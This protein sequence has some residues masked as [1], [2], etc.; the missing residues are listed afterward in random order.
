MG[1]D[2]GADEG[3]ELDEFGRDVNVM[4]RAE[5]GARRARRR[6]RGDAELAAF[7]A[8]QVRGGDA[9]LLAPCAPLWRSR[10][11]HADPDKSALPAR[12]HAL[13]LPCW[14]QFAVV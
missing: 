4:R 14:L 3:V 9:P 2:A 8:R 5:A 12:L 1:G 13:T 6:A 10:H 11:D 7:S